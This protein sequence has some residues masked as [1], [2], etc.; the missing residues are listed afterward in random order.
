[1]LVY[2]FP[3]IPARR[4]FPRELKLRCPRARNAAF[5]EAGHLVV[6]IMLRIEMRL[7]CIS[8]EDPHI[9]TQPHN[10]RGLDYPA[11]IMTYAGGIAEQRVCVRRVWYNSLSDRTWAAMHARYRLRI[12]S[13]AQRRAR[14]L[15]DQHWS[16]IT[17]VANHLMRHGTIYRL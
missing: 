6:G 10:M 1:M 16:L 17:K 14:G 13:T 11:I 12:M 5:H 15:V 3:P 7:A 4:G 9:R 8:Y 2:R